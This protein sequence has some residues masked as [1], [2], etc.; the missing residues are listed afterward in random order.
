M[1]AR[2]IKERV[3]KCLRTTMQVIF[4]FFFLDCSYYFFYSLSFI[5]I[6]FLF[7]E[8]KNCCSRTISES[9]FVCFK[10]YII[11]RKRKK[12]FFFSSFIPF[13]NNF[14]N[15][16]ITQNI[17]RELFFGANQQP[18]NSNFVPIFETGDNFFFF[19]ILLFSYFSH[20]SPPQ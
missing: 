1:M 4:F 3:R 7:E 17:Q 9:D 2:M 14:N 8:N 16:K 12:G 6:Y 13:N 18:Q 20:S 5:F 11:C 19:F 15:P 10:S